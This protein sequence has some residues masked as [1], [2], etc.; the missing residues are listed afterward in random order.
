MKRRG[1]GENPSLKKLSERVYKAFGFWVGEL[2]TRLSG[3]R[4]ESWGIVV[5]EKGI[6]REMA[7]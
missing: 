2:K 6:V 5:F 7:I 1:V 4:N 3:V